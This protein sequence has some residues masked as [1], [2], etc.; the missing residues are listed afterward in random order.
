MAGFVFR[1]FAR[2]FVVLSYFDM[3]FPVF[4]SFHMAFFVFWHG[5]FLSFQ[6]A[7][8]NTAFCRPFVFLHGA[9]S[10]FCPFVWRLFVFSRA[11]FSP[12]KDKKTEWHTPA[13]IGN[14]L[15][16]APEPLTMYLC[17]GIAAYTHISCA[18]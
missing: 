4:S 5:V 12:R 7:S 6:V 13:T 10:S 9:F 17:V 11:V 16:G 1:L 15:T 8:F 14:R 3:A 18:Y 2:R